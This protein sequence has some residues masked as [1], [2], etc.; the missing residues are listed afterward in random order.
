MNNPLLTFHFTPLPELEQTFR[1]TKYTKAFSFSDEPNAQLCCARFEVCTR[2]S[3][4]PTNSSNFSNPS[5]DGLE[6]LYRKTI[7]LPRG[8]FAGEE[9]E[10]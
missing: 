8:I 5:V 1:R 3:T 10:G 9:Y 6:K 4:N 7:A 2:T